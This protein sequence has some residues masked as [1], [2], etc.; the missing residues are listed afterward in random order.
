[1]TKHEVGENTAWYTLQFGEVY[2]ANSERKKRLGRP[3]RRRDDKIKTGIY[4]I[5][6]GLESTGRFWRICN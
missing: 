5:R 3:R 4:E 6:Q 1:M 2:I